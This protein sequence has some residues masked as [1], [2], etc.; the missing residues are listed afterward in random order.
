MI[1]R[2]LGSTS[3][4]AIVLGAG[5][6]GLMCALTAGRRGKRV[7]L[8]DHLEEAGAKILISGG[9]RCNFTNLEVTPERFLS[10]NPDFCK[11][12]L[13][14]Y[15]ERDFIAMVEQHRIPYHEKTQGQLFCDGSA[16]EIVAMLLAECAGVRVTLG[17]GQ[18]VVEVSRAEHFRVETER[19]V[20]DAPALV[21][22]TGGLSIPQMGA[23]GFAY[24]LARRFGL[25]VIEPR[26][27][28]TPLKLAGTSLELARRLTGV[29]VDA[30]VI[31]GRDRFRD[32]VLFTHRGLSGPAILQISSYWRIGQSITIDLLP[33]L[34]AMDFLHDRKRVRPRA[35][36]KTLLSEV[37]PN[38]LADALCEES[39][40]GPIANLPDR[41]LM[42][43]SDRLKH[44]EIRPTGS[45]GWNKAEVTAGGIDTAGLSS[46]TMA[47]RTVPGLFFIG[48]AIDVT[49]WL[50]G[51]NFQWAWSSGWCAGEAL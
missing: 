34:A 14:R 44:R 19:A 26:P 3:F 51:Y 32:Q 4:D 15:T 33:D 8:I 39:P 22:A 11:S 47:A 38:R 6:A 10:A 48:E 46:R 2:F 50:G 13:I 36:L 43:M 29:S 1:G 35:E 21:I 42:R 7:I 17:L 24:D 12:A 41:S 37:L 25:N 45:E 9:G 28:L 40:P 30:L 20:F 31:C 27:G 49:G 23:T 5:A 16:R 18:R